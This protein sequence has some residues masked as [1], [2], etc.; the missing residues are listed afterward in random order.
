MSIV[1]RQYRSVYLPVVVYSLINPFHVIHV[2]SFLKMYP[3]NSNCG[4]SIVAA[5]YQI[6]IDKVLKLTYL[7]VSSY[8]LFSS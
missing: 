5:L 1:D 4:L 8:S 2:F 7:L 3:D 6:V